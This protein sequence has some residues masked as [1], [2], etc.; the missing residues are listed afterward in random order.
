MRADYYN[1]KLATWEPVIEQ[2]SSQV[3]LEFTTNDNIRAYL[4]SSERLNVNITNEFF[5]TMWTTLT[6]WQENF[7]KAESSQ[8]EII[9]P[10]VLKNET[11]QKIK[12][13]LADMVHTL[14]L[15][16]YMQESTVQSL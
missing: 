15:Y 13:W 11:G 9:H 6:A 12:Y 14:E 3:Q 8:R 1:Q 10:F 5:E 2:W 4:R 7:G 16:S